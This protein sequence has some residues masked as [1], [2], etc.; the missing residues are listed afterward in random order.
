VDARRRQ[1]VVDTAREAT[2]AGCGAALWR[3][4]LY[5]DAQASM[6]AMRPPG[7]MAEHDFSAQCIKCGQSAS[8]C[9]YDTLKMATPADAVATGTPY[10][11]PRRIPCYMCKDIPCTCACPTGALSSYL[12]RIEDAR[13]GPAVI[14]QEN[15]LSWKGLRCEI[16]YR[17]C[18]VKGRAITLEERRRAISLHAM[19][20]PI[21][22]SSDCTGCG[23][24]EQACPTEKAAIRVVNPK[25]VMGKIGE[26]YRLGWTEP[27]PKLNSPPAPNP[28][29]AVLPPPMPQ[30]T[31]APTKAPGMDYLNSGAL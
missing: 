24:C 12:R 14:D 1:F 31:P 28:P 3:W 23:L 30:E 29:A 7:A 9:P 26:H 2:L 20:L 21:V 4:L 19:F 5:S 25:L 15:C 18:P 17:V 6:D 13:M 11:T 27:A 8:A 22:H 10:F 16:C